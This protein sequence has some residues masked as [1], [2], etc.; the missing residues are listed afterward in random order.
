LRGLFVEES[1]ALAEN[2]GAPRNAAE[3]LATCLRWDALSSEGKA[4]AAQQPSSPSSSRCSSLSS[5]VSPGL[6]SSAF[7][8]SSASSERAEHLREADRVD[9]VLFVVK[10]VGGVE[11]LRVSSGERGGGRRRAAAAEHWSLEAVPLPRKSFPASA[12]LSRP[13]F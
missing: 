11:L 2:G 5:S 3:R 4:S 6:S 1:P 10:A 13:K 12:V 9:S 8:C 7:G